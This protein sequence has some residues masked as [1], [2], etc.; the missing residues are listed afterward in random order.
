MIILFIRYFC[1]VILHKF[2]ILLA[3]IR[4]NKILRSTSYQ[5]SYKRLL[6]HDLSKFS[7]SEFWP[8]AEHFYGEKKHPEEFHKA[9]LHHV[10]HNDHHWEHFI[11]NYPLWDHQQI[12]DLIIHQMPDDAILEMVAD[13]LAATRSY[14][15]YWPDGKKKDGWSWIT[16]SFEKYGLHSISKMKFAAILCALGYARVLPKEFD[17]T[18]IEK[19]NISNAEKKKVLQL[20]KL[21]Q[22]NN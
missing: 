8:Y 14:E 9:W 17:W 20:E 11:D 19:M 10:A 13:N 7:P 6:L 1:A 2:C 18:T 12:N 21:A 15:G 22:L 5:V 4:M 16:N 3:G